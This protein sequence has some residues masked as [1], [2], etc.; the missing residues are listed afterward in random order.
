[1][2][3][4]SFLRK[5][6]ASKGDNANSIERNVPEAKEVNKDN[7]DA[8]SIEKNAP[9][10]KVVHKDN[11]KAVLESEIKSFFPETG[12]WGS[13]CFR[14]SNEVADANLPCHLRDNAW[15][16]KLLHSR[17]IGKGIYIPQS[18]IK[19]FMDNSEDFENLRHEYELK[20]VK[21]Q[22]KW[23]ITG[24][25]GWL[26]PKGYD[27]ISLLCSE[28]IDK[29]VR[30]GVANTLKA[31]G[32]N[33]SVIEEGLE[34]YADNWRPRSMKRGFCHKYEP[35]FAFMGWT[36][37]ADKEHEKNWLAD[38]EYTYYQE[39][40]QSVDAYGTKTPA[41]KMTPEEHAQLVTILEKQNAQ[42]LS[43][44]ENWKVENGISPK[45]GKQETTII[46][47]DEKIN[48]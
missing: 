40:K 46:D 37:E 41:M 19:R 32:M 47:N 27:E 22:I 5:K 2:D 21:W 10:A 4:L 26:L 18:A 23:V 42:R 45:R 30:G 14:R 43:Y 6:R 12:E 44:I 33:R 29:I 9:G 34:K 38:R 3:I 11:I 31:I 25:E 1:M 8:D 24:G 16:S 15:M 7:I 36:G 20:I 17:L 35:F 28:D 48:L 39:H 13:L